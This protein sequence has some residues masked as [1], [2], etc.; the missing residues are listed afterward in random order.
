MLER[1]TV[2][3]FRNIDSAELSFAPGLNLVVGENAAGKTSLLEAVHCLGRARSFL[4]VSLDQ[5]TKRGADGW[6]VRGEI[7]SGEERHTLGV[8]RFSKRTRVRLD[9]E[10]VGRLSDVAWLVPVQVL[11][12]RSQRLLTD[13][14]DERRGF[15]N[16]AVFHVEHGFAQ[17]WRRYERA[18]RQR[19]AALRAGD[20]RLA[21]AWEPEMA[22]AGAQVD[23]SRGRLLGE[24]EPYWRG[25]IDRWLPSCDVEWRYKRGWSTE[26][27]LGELLA[28]ERAR[29]QEL[30]YSVNGPHRADL[31]V[32]AAGRDAS[33]EL[34]RGQQKLVVTALRFSLVERLTRLDSG[35]RP[36]VLMDDLPAEL[37]ANN[38]DRL[39]AA[40]TTLGAQVVVTA[41]GRDQLAL[42]CSSVERLF[43]VEQGSYR[44]LL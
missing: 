34:S 27:G 16:W 3:G 28:S 24:L 13:G 44:E 9:G 35:V 1:L 41:I 21:S 40:A 36:I 30:G 8:G 42:D 39:V 14:P 33:K 23:E 10:S 6:W 31:R 25:W 29:E 38:Q 4:P 19:N 22:E 2:S 15:L 37:D 12:T 18:L 17:H 43:H 32:V 26:A 5:L 7:E 11:N 20:E